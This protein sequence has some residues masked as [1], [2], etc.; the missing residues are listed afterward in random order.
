MIFKPF[1]VVMIS[2]LV[3]IMGACQPLPGQI[4]EN[5]T[6]SVTFE[7]PTPMQLKIRLQ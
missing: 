2:I 4:G 1:R 5:E 6:H 3:L 7:N